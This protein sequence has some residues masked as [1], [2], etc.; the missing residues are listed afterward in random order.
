MKVETPRPSA[1]PYLGLNGVKS[2]MNLRGLMH[3]CVRQIKGCYACHKSAL[4]C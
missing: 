2:G 4:A 3:E 1:N